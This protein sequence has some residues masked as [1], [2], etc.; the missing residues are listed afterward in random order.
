MIT[1]CFLVFD[2]STES[3][4]LIRAS[5]FKADIY[6]L[7]S[8]FLTSFRPN[9]LTYRQYK[10]PVRSDN[11]YRTEGLLLNS[12]S[13]INHYVLEGMDHNVPLAVVISGPQHD[14]KKMQQ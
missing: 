9:E 6:S 2:F 8:L 7:H 1:R 5:R 10:L 4:G 14:L 13:F 11:K 12:R 3:K